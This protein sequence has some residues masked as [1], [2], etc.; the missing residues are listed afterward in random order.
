MDLL[1]ATE[2]SS[3][4]NSTPMNLLSARDRLHLEQEERAIARL[5][6]RRQR[7]QEGRRSEWTEVRQ[8]R[9]D[10]RSIHSEESVVFN[11]SIGVKL[12]KGPSCDCQLA[13]NIKF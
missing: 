3:P 1:N 2:D 11:G 5:Q 4:C 9:L 7:E 6:R 8:A 10:R 13:Q 12:V